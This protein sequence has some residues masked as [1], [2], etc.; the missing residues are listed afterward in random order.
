MGIK[1]TIH[2][3]VTKLW[4][5][6][7]FREFIPDD[8]EILS[9]VRAVYAEGAGDLVLENGRGEAVTF[10]LATDDGVG[11]PLSPRRVME[12]STVSKVILIY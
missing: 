8:G 10:V 6:G 9:E 12:S 5:S 11:F 3:D 7:D 2:D 4:P 1:A